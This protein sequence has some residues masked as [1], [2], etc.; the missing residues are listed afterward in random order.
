MGIEEQTKLKPTGQRIQKA[1][2]TPKIIA[3]ISGNILSVSPSFTQVS[4][5]TSENLTQNGGLESLFDSQNTYTE[6]LE[7]IQNG[8]NWEGHTI[9]LDARQDEF[10]ALVKA[11]PYKNGR[12]ESLISIDFFDIARSKK[13]ELVETRLLKAITQCTEVLFSKTN[14]AE[15]IPKVIETIG[16]AM[17]VQRAYL[18][19]IIKNPEGVFAE[20]RFEWVR[21]AQYNTKEFKQLKSFDYS[22]FWPIYQILLNGKDAAITPRTKIDEAI[23]KSLSTLNIHALLKIPIFIDGNLW[24]YIGFEDTENIREWTR[25]EKK[26]LKSLAHNIGALLKINSLTEELITKNRQLENAIEGAT[27]GLWVWDLQKNE[28][29]ISP[30][31]YNIFGYAPGEWGSNIIPIKNLLK[32]EDTE[33][34]ELQ[35]HQAIAKRQQN[36]DFET[37]CKHKKGRYVW[38]KG[39]VNLTYDKIGNIV[40][41]SGSVSDISTE[42]LYEL[43]I[44]RQEEHYQRLVNSL[45]EVVFETDRTGTITFLNNSWKTLTGRNIKESIGEKLESFVDAQYVGLLEEIFTQL[46]AKQIWPGR[47]EIQIIRSGK[48]YWTEVWLRGLYDSNYELTG[49]SGSI[50]DINSKKIA[51]YQLR[52]SEE[53]YRLLSE[54]TKDIICLHD[55]ESRYVYVSPSMKEM[56]GYPPRAL[57]GSFAWSCIHPNELTQVKDAF[58][59]LAKGKQTGFIRY[60]VKHRNG[61]YIWVET[62]ASIQQQPADKGGNLLIQTATRDISQQKKAEEE[63]INALE[64]E[65]Q[66][67][68]LRTNLINMISHEFRT[69]L[70]TIKSSSDLMVRYLP[71]LRKSDVKDRFGQ[72]FQKILEQVNRIN[73]LISGVLQLGRIDSGKIQYNP[74]PVNFVSYIQDFLHQY[75]ESHP[76]EK[77][78]PKLTFEGTPRE[79]KIDQ[80]LVLHI[81]NNVVS[82]ALKYSVGKKNPDL[83]IKFERKLVEITIKDYGIGIA[84]NDRKNLFQSFYRGSNAF[85][86]PGTGL[87]LVIVKQ[88]V[89]MHGGTIEL[90]SKLNRGTTILITLPI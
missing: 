26:S 7:H 48:A 85:T 25:A 41:H 57:L 74:E 19:Q 23:L 34:L 43:K 50:F 31:M 29:Y 36:F 80:M 5:Y 39:V 4:K 24:G 20:R 27:D 68:E 2:E 18:Y 49:V 71:A 47:T 61:H 35:L 87:G 55:I 13:N 88:F 3:G 14:P 40:R 54:N 6:I 69:P 72:H 28:T 12:K 8:K 53:S 79:V 1:A 86:I 59:K 44:R 75:K 77:R 78:L 9:L 46:R 65:R 83:N 17:L 73:D 33:I 32:T 70:T 63:I 64:K 42:K 90:T 16:K 22:T 66:L 62:V 51:E 56:L 21:A 84:E 30:R 15:V 89:E 37:V 58:A 81:L 11:A 67:V 60:R 38:I 52:E 82:N 45:K 10:V 76:E